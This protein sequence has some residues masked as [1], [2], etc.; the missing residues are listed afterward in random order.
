[1]GKPVES[2]E[3]F[4]KALALCRKLVDDNPANTQFQLELANFQ[5]NIG[6]SLVRQKRL[7]EAFAA[8]DAG[9][10]IRQKLADENPRVPDFRDALA[11]SHDDLADVFRSLGR[12]A[13]T[14][15]AY[16]RAVVLRERLVHENPTIPR[17]LF[18]VADSLRRRG[19]AR[20]DLGDPAGAA[21]DARRALGLYEA[22]PDRSGEQW[23][24]TACCHA[25]LCGLSGHDGAGV[26]AAEGEDEAARAIAALTRAV[27][28]GYRNA[29]AWRTESALDPL[30]SRDDFR[31]LLMDVAFPAEPFAR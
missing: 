3:A 29:Y 27:G 13:Q 28:M 8:I 10:V 12:A 14:C 15:D 9:L 18:N 30:R 23:F 1:M 19:L 17:Y 6:Q 22:L 20:H 24:G 5:T 7:G 16:E 11:S 31:L 4:R 21:A 2:A 26:S 25:A